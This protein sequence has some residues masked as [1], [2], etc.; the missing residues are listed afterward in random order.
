MLYRIVEHYDTENYCSDIIPIEK[1]N[2]EECFVCLQDEIGNNIPIKLLNQNLYIKTC[3]CDGYIHLNCLTRWYNKNLSCPICRGHML[4]IQN[5][6]IYSLSKNKK[7]ATFVYLNIYEPFMSLK[8]SFICR[9][10]LL[11][12]LVTIFYTLFCITWYAF[13]LSKYN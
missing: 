3:S 10:I 13:I 2:I 12:I 1:Q 7:I 11:F 4:I 9:R 8:K 5:N 6:K